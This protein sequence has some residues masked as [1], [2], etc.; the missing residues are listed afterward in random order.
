[1]V[2]FVVDEE[3]VAGLVFVGVLVVVVLVLFVSINVHCGCSHS[4]GCLIVEISKIVVG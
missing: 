1:V 2:V 3:E 4:C